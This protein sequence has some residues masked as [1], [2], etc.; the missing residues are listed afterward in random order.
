[1]I[2]WPRKKHNMKTGKPPIAHDTAVRLGL[3]LFWA[4]LFVGIV[5]GMG[6]E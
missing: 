3:V 1:M 4:G 2:H 5:L 6:L